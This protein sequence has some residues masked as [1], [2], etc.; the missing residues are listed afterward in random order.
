MKILYLIT[1]ADLGGAQVHLVDL[2]EGLRGKVEPVLGVGEEGYLTGVAKRM[3]VEHHVMPELVHPIRPLKDARALRRIVQLIGKTRP[4]LIHAHTSKAGVLGRL[5]AGLAGVPAVFTAHTWAFA[6]GTSLKWRAFGI[7]S[8]RLAARFSARIINVSAANRG[9]ALQ[10]RIGDEGKHLTIY[11]GV[12]DTAL[13]AKP[14]EGDPP[15]FIMVARFVPQK[16]QGALLRAVAQLDR[17]LRLTFVGDG[18]LRAGLEQEA[19]RLG[20]QERVEFLGERRDIPELLSQSHVFL[21]ATN[22]EGFPLSILEAMRA[23]LPVVSTDAG[24]VREAIVPGET[25]FVL[26]NNDPSTWCACLQSLLDSPALRQRLGDAARSR[27]ESL[28]TL[29]G[30]ARQTLA[31]Y[32]AVVPQ[33]VANEAATGLRKTSLPTLLSE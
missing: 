25:G 12:P 23:G 8:E 30:M 16:A 7:P 27:Y 19:R 31:V 11:N 28:F 21:L 3:G 20:I 15:R 29:S 13:R 5:A 32:R 22:W 2:I 14:G 10:N 17:P 9:L 33:I 18:P 4:N 1:R 24:G 6:E 26:P